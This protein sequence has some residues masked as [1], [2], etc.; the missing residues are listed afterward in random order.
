MAAFI[1][2]QKDLKRLGKEILNEIFDFLHDEYILTKFKEMKVLQKVFM[3]KLELNNISIE[4][5]KVRTNDTDA[6][7]KVVRYINFDMEIDEDLYYKKMAY[8]DIFR[9]FEVSYMYF[10]LNFNIKLFNI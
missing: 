7:Y 8:M 5:G 10:I 9:V 1:I 4:D 2:R 6:I 3:D